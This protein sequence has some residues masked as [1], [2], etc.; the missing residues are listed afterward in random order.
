MS[1]FFYKFIANPRAVEF[2]IR[3][4]VKFTPIDELNDPS[5]LSPT[6]VTEDVVASLARLRRDGYTEEDLVHLRRQG[7][8]LQR[9]APRFQAVGVPSSTDEAAALIRAPFYDSVSALERLLEETAREMSSKVGLLCLS[10]RYDSLP[11][12]AHYAANA[13]GVVVEFRD[14]DNVFRGDDTG[15]LNAV[16]SVRY[17][18]ERGGVTFD[19]RS[20]EALFFDKFT[21]WSYEQ[22]ARVVLPLAECRRTS[23]NGNSLYLYDLPLECISRV[24]LGWRLS[25]VEADAVRSIVG[26]VHPRVNIHQA[27]FERGRVRI[28]A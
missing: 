10:R 28:G 7:S 17:A 2:L 21:D 12:W 5:E 25:G 13:S 3:G 1:D 11:M 26:S 22:E 24:I 14:L 4:A 23:V 6:F 16:I 8:L 27:R 18:S 20:H 19:P 15:V 9:L